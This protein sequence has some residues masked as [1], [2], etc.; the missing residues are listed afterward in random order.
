MYVSMYVCVYVYSDIASVPW[1]GTRISF[2]WKPLK[3]A[4]VFAYTLCISLF[5]IM[6][7]QIHLQVFLMY[8]LTKSTHVPCI[9][10]AMYLCPFML[11]GCPWACTLHMCFAWESV[12]K[13]YENGLC[14]SV[15]VLSTTP[16]MYVFVCVHVHPCMHVRQCVSTMQP[17]S[18]GSMQ[19]GTGTG[20]LMFLKWIWFDTSCSI[21]SIC[22]AGF[23][24]LCGSGSLMLSVGCGLAYQF[25]Y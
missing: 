12:W 7:A 13:A 3:N 6:G 8:T 15:C 20:I 25:C 18:G 22:L 2:H 16:C 10:L 9:L 24:I 17:Y 1:V 23:V 21:V 11:S 5:G 19:E 14:L 4:Y